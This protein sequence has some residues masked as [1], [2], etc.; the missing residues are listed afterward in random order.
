M[1]QAISGPST[2]QGDILRVLYNSL[3]W[4]QGKAIGIPMEIWEPREEGTQK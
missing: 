1:D 4:D 3:P 2:W